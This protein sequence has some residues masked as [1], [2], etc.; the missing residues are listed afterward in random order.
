MH[1]TFIAIP[2][3]D[4]TRAA[5]RPLARTLEAEMPAGAFAFL[6]PENWHITLS[7]LGDQSDEEVG[8][9]VAA[10]PSLVPMLGM[11]SEVHFDRIAYWPNNEDPSA[12]ALVG[13]GDA[14]AVLGEVRDILEDGLIAHE[15][16][17]RP[18][19]RRFVTHITLAK[20]TLGRSGGTPGLA[21]E[22]VLLPELE[23]VADITVTPESVT[24]FESYPEKGKPRYELLASE[25]VIERGDNEVI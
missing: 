4:D 7:F 8:Q 20:R 1:R 12:I 10:L 18:D 15:V 9:V 22:S 25:V 19:N 11:P 17:F 6:D 23:Q 24:Y 13:S 14:S 3:S 21:K 5:L 2:L 16:R